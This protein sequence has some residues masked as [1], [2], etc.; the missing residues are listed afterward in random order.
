MSP[1]ASIPENDLT[2]E[3][4]NFLSSA[5]TPSSKIENENTSANI[6]EELRLKRLAR[7]N[8]QLIEAKNLSPIPDNQQTF[9][10]LSKSVDKL[11]CKTSSF[12]PS[13]DVKIN[14]KSSLP[15]NT[16]FTSRSDKNWFKDQKWLKVPE[17][18]SLAEPH[19]TQQLQDWL[20]SVGKYQNLGDLETLLDW[21]NNKPTS[22][23]DYKGQMVEP[24]NRDCVLIRQENHIVELPEEVEL[25]KVDS[26]G[27]FKINLLNGDSFS[28]IFENGEREG[29]G[30][31]KF[32]V[33]NKRKYEMLEIEGNYESDILQGNGS[34]SYVNGE[35]LV[36]MFVDG[37]PNGPAKL[38][39]GE[40]QIK[41]IG[42]M[43][44]GK[45]TG[46]VWHWFKGGSYITGHVDFFGNLT[47][48]SI[49]FIYPDLKHVL[50]G[51][52]TKGRL[53][54]GQLCY[55]TNIRFIKADFPKL[56]YTP[57]GQGPTYTFDDR[58]TRDYACETPLDPDPYEMNTICIKKSKLYG[59][60]EGV[61]LKVDVPSGRTVAFYNGVHKTELELEEDPL[62]WEA[63][64][65][66]IMDMLGKDPV[67]GLTSVIDIPD[68]YISTKNYVASLAH[69]CNHSF[70]PNATFLLGYSPR[71]GLIPT[72][73]A[74]RDIKAGEELFCSY[75][76]KLNGA[77]SWYL[78]LRFIPHKM[79]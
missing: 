73:N 35:K 49:A 47:G 10:G 26:T 38:F 43:N 12:K 33:I 70:E 36:C 7:R 42:V 48:D 59:S 51:T 64:A 66:K 5:T 68:E 52:F 76:Y 11:E 6:I 3:P 77:P 40:N 22:L 41:Q 1:T 54:L 65:Y 34:I 71:F 46:Q 27:K 4:V 57:T 72:V 18:Y 58:R 39:D 62:D 32:G 8:Q 13:E 63:N 74:L 23:K 20:D 9:T 53:S 44:K 19:K 61:Y 45:W 37:V 24:Y 31:L 15:S 17:D 55:V 29:P 16:K 78:R 56:T 79:S 50:L 69:K 75:D 67:T 30:I 21:E 60:G 28:G 14:R 2:E 25:L